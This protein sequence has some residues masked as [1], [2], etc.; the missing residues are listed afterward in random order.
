M[1][2]DKR[3]TIPEKIIEVLS[4]SQAPLACHEFPFPEI[5]TSHSVISARLRELARE[6]KVTSVRF[7]GERFKRWIIKKGQQELF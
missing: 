7:E 5:P 1:T 4:Q 3:K 6:G 2:T